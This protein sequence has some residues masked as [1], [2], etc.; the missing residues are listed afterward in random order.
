MFVLKHVVQT[1]VKKQ[2]TVSVTKEELVRFVED[3]IGTKRTAELEDRALLNKALFLMNCEAVRLSDFPDSSEEVLES[4][5]NTK[6]NRRASMKKH[7]VEVTFREWVKRDFTY[8]VPL[9][10]IARVLGKTEEE[11]LKVWKSDRRWESALYKEIESLLESA[12][13]TGF[14]Y[15]DPHFEFIPS[16]LVLDEDEGTCYVGGDVFESQEDINLDNVK[17]YVEEE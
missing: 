9:A 5:S 11:T 15:E 16:P 10:D 12:R 1:V 8:H 14:E 17:F 13:Y 3:K 7:M 2:V 6:S 4:H